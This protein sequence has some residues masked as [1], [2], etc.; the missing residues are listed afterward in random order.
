M[1]F[2]KCPLAAHRPVGTGEHD[3]AGEPSSQH[4]EEKEGELVEAYP[5]LVLVMGNLNVGKGYD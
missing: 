4:R 2:S 5:V 1:S 3:P